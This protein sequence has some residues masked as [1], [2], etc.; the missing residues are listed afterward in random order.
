MLNNRRKFI[1]QISAL[2]GVGIVAAT[3]INDLSAANFNATINDANEAITLT[4]L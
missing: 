3:C 4:I 2:G 1:Q